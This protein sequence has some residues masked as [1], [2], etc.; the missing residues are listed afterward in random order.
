MSAQKENNKFVEGLDST[1]GAA[2]ADEAAAAIESLAVSVPG[3]CVCVCV[4]SIELT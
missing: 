2:E 1:E 3:V 4:L